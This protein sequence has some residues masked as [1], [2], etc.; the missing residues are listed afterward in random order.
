MMMTTAF[1]SFFISVCDLMHSL[2]LL[3]HGSVFIMASSA[4][5][6]SD[7]ITYDRQNNTNADQREAYGTG[8]SAE[9][10]SFG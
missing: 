10:K 7:I 1:M 9:I 3:N 2:L 6:R 4:R 5:I 8:N